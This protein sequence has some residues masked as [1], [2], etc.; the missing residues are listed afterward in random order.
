MSSALIQVLE[1]PCFRSLWCN[2]FFERGYAPFYLKPVQTG[3][4]DSYDSGSDARFVYENSGPLRDKDPAGS[5]VYCF[6]NPK[7]PVYAARDEGRTVDFQVIETEVLRISSLFRPVIIEAAGGVLVPVTEDMLVADMIGPLGGTPVIAA[8]AG[9]GTINHTLL[10]IEALDRRGIKPAGVVF[11]DAGEQATPPDMIRENR[12]AVE[13]IS[14]VKVAGVVGRIS[15]F[16]RPPGE[17]YQPI[18]RIWERLAGC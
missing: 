15:D 10:T 5:V 13:S 4:M 16:S 11:I 14:G 6:R 8:R 7:A 17:S 2:F 18:I 1:R 9:L 12:L 3:C